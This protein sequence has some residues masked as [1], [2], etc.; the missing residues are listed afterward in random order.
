MG[1]ALSGEA[2]D[3]ERGA[4]ALVDLRP[5]PGGRAMDQLGQDNNLKTSE[6]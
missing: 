4:E 5:Q 2:E 3:E 1:V 6:H